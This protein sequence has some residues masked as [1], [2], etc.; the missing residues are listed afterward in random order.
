MSFVY[1]KSHQSVDGLPLTLIE[2]FRKT[3]LYEIY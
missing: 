3:K 1:H 2:T